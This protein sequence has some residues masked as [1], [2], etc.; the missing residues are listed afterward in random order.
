MLRKHPEVLVQNPL[1]LLKHGF[2]TYTDEDRKVLARSDREAK[3]DIERDRRLAPGEVTSILNV[4]EGQMPAAVCGASLARS[5]GTR[6]G[7]GSGAEG[8]CRDDGL[9]RR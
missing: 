4:L 6:H 2:S 1:R 9:G 8:T 5:S 7:A 3:Y